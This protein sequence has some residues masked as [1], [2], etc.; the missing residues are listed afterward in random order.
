LVRLSETPEEARPLVDLLVD[1]RLLAT[2]VAKGTGETTIEPAHEAPLR[3]WGLLQGWL[4]QDAGL[5]T[6]VDGIKRAARDWAAN[7]KAA[8]WLAHVAERLHAA[9]RLMARE[10]LSAIRETIDRDDATTNLADA[11]QTGRK[12]ELPKLRQRVG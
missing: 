9:E 1:Q 6:V 10:H 3:Q 12:R 11:Q 4:T 2:D 8:P 5:L 7:D